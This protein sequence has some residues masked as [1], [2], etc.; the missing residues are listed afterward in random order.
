MNVAPEVEFVVVSPVPGLSRVGAYKGNRMDGYI[1]DFLP[2]GT[3]V[4]NVRKFPYELK[5]FF[6]DVDGVEYVFWKNT[7]KR[8]PREKKAKDQ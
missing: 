1:T 8:K 2:V 5:K 4:N 3:V 6:G 7:L